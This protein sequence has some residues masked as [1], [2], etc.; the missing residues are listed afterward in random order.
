M[1]HLIQLIDRSLENLNNDVIQ[2]EL[3]DLMIAARHEVQKYKK[4]LVV[5]FVFMLLSYFCM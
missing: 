1:E 3:S 5:C 2:D 4:N